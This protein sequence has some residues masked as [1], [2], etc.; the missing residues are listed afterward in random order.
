MNLKE[1]FRFQNKLN[2]LI[3][4][5]EEILKN[6]GNTMKVTNTVMKNRVD[7]EAENEVR[8]E[9]YRFSLFDLEGKV[10]TLSDFL[11]YLFE[12]KRKLSL[13]IEKTKSSLDI[14]ID[15]ETSLNA[16]RQ[17]IM[18]VFSNMVSLRSSETVISKGGIGYRFN[19]EGNQ[20]PYKCDIKVVRTINFDRNRVKS[21]LKKL[22][23]ESDE[24]SSKLDLALVSSSVDYTPPFDVN[25]S[26][27]EIFEEFAD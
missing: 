16:K 4:K 8:R 15:A 7:R 23:R 1:A 25:D 21:Y 2:E 22:S 18:T 14:D 17:E 20:T 12:E 9:A 27:V 26:F 6:E 10:T 24:T 11:M 13:M 19:A 5:T 3:T